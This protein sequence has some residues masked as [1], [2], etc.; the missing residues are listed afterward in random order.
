NAI[1]ENILQLSRKRDEI[2]QVIGVRE[3]LEQFV[4]KFTS[5]NSEP[6]NIALDVRDDAMQ[7]RAN[8][9]QLE[10]LMTNL[11]DNGLRYSRRHRG[12]PELR[13]EAGL[14]PHSEA[15]YIDVIDEGPGI[16]RQDEEKIFEPFFTT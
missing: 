11:C 1:I 7:I 15:R 3:W 10:Q 16:E 9:S 2:P 4:W 5:S 13:I 12:R 8:P 6:V 14:L